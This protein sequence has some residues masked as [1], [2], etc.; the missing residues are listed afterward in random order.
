MDTQKQSRGGKN[1]IMLNLL[2][3]YIDKLFGVMTVDEYKSSLEI[4]YKNNPELEFYD[5][6]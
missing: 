6:Y 5:N 3:K 4:R 1:K 2:F